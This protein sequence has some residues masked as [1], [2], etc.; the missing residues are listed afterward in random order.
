[1]KNIIGI[2]F[3]HGETSAGFV[4]S[5]N[6]IGNEVQMSDLNIVG[7]E[8]V[9]PSVV[10]TMPSDEVV[11]SPNADQIA[12][13]KK[14]GISFKD[15]LVGSAEYT[16]ITDTNKEYFK[17]FLSK[18]YEAIK[19]NSNNPLH[20]SQDGQ[21]DFIVY[22]ACPSGWNQ[23]QIDAYKEFTNTQCGIPVMDI[24]KE[25][26]AAYIAAR[27]TVTGGI[28][29]QGGNVL[30][31]DFGS[32][33]ID[34]TYFNNDSRFEPVHEGY[35]LGARIIEERFLNYLKEHEP[36]ANENI[37]LVEN[38]CGVDKGKNVLLFAIRK[39]KE[40]YFI[41]QNQDKF[42]LSIDL[43]RLLLDNSLRNRYIEPESG[44]G[45]S[46]QEVLDILSGY[47]DKLGDMLDDFLTKD[48]VTSV[49]KVILTGGASRMFFFKDLVAEKYNVS[50]DNDTLIVDLNPSVTISRGISAF[51]YMNE[52][53]TPREKA[54]K[55][56]VEDWISNQMPQLLK[57][58]IEKCIGDMY[59]SE[60]SQITHRYSFGGIVKEGKHNLD[61]LEDEIITLLNNWS[62]SGEVISNK[63][64]KVIKENMMSSI[65]E[66]ISEYARTW[67]YDANNTDFNINLKLDMQASLTYDTC[68]NLIHFM[69]GNL[70][71]FISD[72]DFWP[73]DDATSPYRDRDC[74]DRES[75]E[76]NLNGNFRSFF[77]DLN[78]I[79]PL[80]D[81]ISQIS[82]S[83]INKLQ[84]FVDNA[85]LQQYR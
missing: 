52:L 33:T 39:L 62:A 66:T 56:Q 9:I 47:I 4:I 64:N 67:G 61:G 53:A 65:G 51:G 59:Y 42:L 78:Y 46:K 74:D 63:I 79:S 15:P 20:T 12:K 84:V 27:R 35:K 30:V 43:R 34:F 71:E 7:E 18:T 54:L 80:N 38:T 5:D 70:K 3:G 81:E 28:R 44:E 37:R 22:I 17:L 25:S 69:W 55:N 72:R 48:G 76:Q 83:V 6:V 8:K 49:D 45:Y 23:E 77:D 85:K 60:F 40:E 26:R 16:K 68:Q 19:S 50:K 75:I 11:I 58:T 14:I 32:S 21:S 24:V 31:I 57:S 13:A 10:C 41:S 2:D 36:E 1:M 73:W 82:S 29:T